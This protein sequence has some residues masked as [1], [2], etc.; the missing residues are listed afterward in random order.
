[1]KQKNFTLTVLSFQREKK[2]GKEKADIWRRRR[3]S[4]SLTAATRGGGAPLWTPRAAFTLIELLVVIAIIAILAAM[5]LPA[6]NKA[7]QTATNI[8]CVS[9]LKQI[10]LSTAMYL[11]H[12][13]GT[14]PT[15][16]DYTTKA[17]WAKTMIE[18][19]QLEAKMIVCPVNRNSEYDKLRNGKTFYNWELIPYGMNWSLQGGVKISNIKNASRKVLVVESVNTSNT[20]PQENSVGHVRVSR[21]RES[22]GFGVPF[23]RHLDL[24]CCNVLMTDGHAESIRTPAIGVAGSNFLY[25]EP[26]KTDLCWNPQD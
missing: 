17:N 15:V 16:Y 2:V 26:L 8:Q 24:R 14:F 19:K 20:E 11:D 3:T 9:Q 18:A 21:Q 12:S 1:M 25:Q 23:A 4:A 6:L 13:D 22:S 7:R 10:G 5:L